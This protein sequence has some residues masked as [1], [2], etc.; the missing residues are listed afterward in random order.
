MESTN[1]NIPHSDQQLL[2]QAEA[3]EIDNDDMK[4]ELIDELKDINR[5]LKDD[6]LTEEEHEE[7]L[8]EWENVM[9]ALEQFDEPE[10]EEEENDERRDDTTP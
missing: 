6:T 1:N 8:C 4:Q 10:E 2:D 7:L 9:M 3:F 5:K